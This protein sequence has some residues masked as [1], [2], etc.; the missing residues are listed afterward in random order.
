NGDW[1][2]AALSL[3]CHLSG[4]PAFI[5]SKRRLRIVADHL[6]PRRID[7]NAKLDPGMRVPYVV[8]SKR[9]GQRLLLTLQ[10]HAELVPS[11]DCVAS[12]SNPVGPQSTTLPSRK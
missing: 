6:E 3:S 10:V 12:G 2:L 9:P 5:R 1:G 8:H 11:G 7:R 4:R